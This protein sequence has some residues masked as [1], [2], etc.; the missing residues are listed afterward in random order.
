MV[1]LGAGIFALWV[2]LV[3]DIWMKYIQKH[4]SGKLGSTG[5]SLQCCA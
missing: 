1:P 2:M 5:F 3:T 4:S